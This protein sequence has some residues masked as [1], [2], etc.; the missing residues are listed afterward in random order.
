ME[1]TRGTYHQCSYVH[2]SAN[3]L[4]TAHR[5]LMSLEQDINHDDPESTHDIAPQQFGYFTFG[6]HPPS[7]ILMPC[8]IMSRR[9]HC[10]L[11]IRERNR[12]MGWTSPD[13]QPWIPWSTRSHWMGIGHGRRISSNM[14]LWH[15]PLYKHISV[16]RTYTVMHISS[17]VV[18]RS[19]IIM[20]L[21]STASRVSFLHLRLPQESPHIIYIEIW[22]PKRS[23]LN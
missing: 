3:D 6:V 14:I 22:S 2:I 13:Q 11:V 17:L 12:R 18:P 8:W 9:F 23:C 15:R 21:T 5:L 19:Y 1:G 7:L 16:D 10:C 4:W 20:N